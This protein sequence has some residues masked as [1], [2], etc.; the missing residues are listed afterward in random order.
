MGEWFSHEVSNFQ[1]SRKGLFLFFPHCN[2]ITTQL[3]GAQWH[4]GPSLKCSCT[5]RILNKN[6][7]PNTRKPKMRY[8]LEPSK[9][10][11]EKGFFHIL[12]SPTFL[13]RRPL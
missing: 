5:F 6:P 7:N 1:N 8:H 3:P 13:F 2:K 4:R 11:Q 12:D 9:I 10:G